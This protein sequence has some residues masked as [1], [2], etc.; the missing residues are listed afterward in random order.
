MRML[1]RKFASTV[2]AVYDRPGAL[3]ER[4][5]TVNSSPDHPQRTSER[6]QEFAHF[7]DQMVL[8]C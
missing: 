6:V 4:P 7:G 3:I 2:W 1:R 5:P 8:S